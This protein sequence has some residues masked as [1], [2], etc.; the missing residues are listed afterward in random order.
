MAKAPFT[1]EYPCPHCGSTDNSGHFGACPNMGLFDF[2]GNPMPALPETNVLSCPTSGCVLGV[3]HPKYCYD[4][5]GLI[6]NTTKDTKAVTEDCP[7]RNCIGSRGHS[8]T[9]FNLRGGILWGPKASDTE[10]RSTSSTGG[11]KGVK[12]ERHSLIPVEPLNEVARHYG[13]GAA[14]Y[15]DHNWRRGYEFSKS[16]DAMRR[17]ESSWWGGEDIDPETG[18]SHLAA[19]VFHAFTLMEFMKT[20]P[21]FDDRYKAPV[22]IDKCDAK[23]AQ[24][25]LDSEEA[26][27][28]LRD[29]LRG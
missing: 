4:A 21:E 24:H 6:L 15:A 28:A 29:R 8:H 19:V 2:Y 9:C 3:N 14:K 5:V 18:T 1:K 13:A 25:N 17:H 20:H 7:T 23:Q 12:P 27:A 16:Y 10:I 26:L 11:E 22:E